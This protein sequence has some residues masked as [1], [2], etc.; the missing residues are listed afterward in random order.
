MTRG[1]KIAWIWVWSAM[2]LVIIGSSFAVWRY[3]G[4]A[5]P[6]LDALACNHGL[7]IS[8]CRRAAAAE[9]VPPVLR[10]AALRQLVVADGYE[11][12]TTVERLSLLIRLGVANAEDWNNRGNA[13]YAL[14]K[15]DRAADD[16]RTAGLM[17]GAVGTYWSNLGDAQVEAG[18]HG[19]AI[20]NY[21][22]AMRKGENNAEVR[23]NRGWA[24]YQLGNLAGALADYDKAILQ[25]PEHID[26]LNER[27]LIHHALGD[28]RTALADFDRS[29]KITP[30]SAAILAN[31][32]SSH[33][34][35]GQWDDALADLDRALS[36]DP[37]YV[38]TR[39]DKAWLFIDRG[40]P[41]N[42]LSVLAA[43]TDFPGFKLQLFEARA[44]A[45]AYLNEWQAVVSNAD[46]AEAL[47]SR[48]A[49]LYQIRADAKYGLGDPEG[50][51]AD[52][53]LALAIQPAHT[54]ALVSRAFALLRTDRPETAHADIDA[55]V[56]TASDRAHALGVRS[57]FN[58]AWGRLAAAL[59]DARE[60]ASLAP[61]SI[62]SALALGRM[63]AEAGDGAAAL[64]QCNN[65]LKL[66]ETART[67]R[68]RALAYLIQ[69]QPGPALLD[70]KRSLALDKTS[71]SAQL[72]LGRI[73]LARG[74]ARS[75]IEVFNEIIRVD[76]YDDADVFMFR[77]DAALALGNFGQ[78]R[79]DYLEAKNRDL[80]QY[81]SALAVRLTTLPAQ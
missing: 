75:A 68:C 4:R 3:G 8:A 22:T 36:L 5:L 24:R 62:D 50:A 42:A 81:G 54:K 56:R 80:G 65:A 78:A 23:G 1:E 35:L 74:D 14:K 77:G 61:D 12:E 67:W 13:H 7:G 27:G 31:R 33:A 53:T 52:A 63:L 2:T 32:S 6:Y 55:L 10:A 47:G 17:N 59:S 20:Y 69:G 15:Y 60:S 64:A 66:R 46:E 43:V 45:H 76:V 18:R 25:Q 70:I 11:P 41:E 34:R 48:A 51:V 72:V 57:Y 19:E 71:S 44:Q 21:T 79:L 26:N 40:Q 37:K 73:E 28:Y 9:Q 29:L 39:L 30:D 49:W 58:L 16:Y 38:P